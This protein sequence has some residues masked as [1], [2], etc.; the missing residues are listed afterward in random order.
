VTETG[1]EHPFRDSLVT[2]MVKLVEVLPK[3]NLTGDVD[4]E[5]LASEVKSS[6]L[7]DPARLRRSDKVRE[8]TARAASE[9]AERM[10]GYMAG[11]SIPESGAAEEPPRQSLEVDTA[12]ASAA[13]AQSGAILFP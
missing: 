9:I 4:L 5:R 12:I 1:V 10:A 6:L 7:V 8:E 13:G 11:Y 3:L 2:N